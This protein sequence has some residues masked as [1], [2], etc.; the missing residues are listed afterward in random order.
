MGKDQ[1]DH[2]D[3]VCKLTDA[4]IVDEDAGIPMLSSDLL[5]GGLN[6]GK[7]CQVDSVV[8]DARHWMRC[9]R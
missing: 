2:F 5:C 3:H 4:G 6:G 9:V 8:V 7:V 1:G